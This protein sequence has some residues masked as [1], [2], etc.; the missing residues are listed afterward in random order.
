M[1]RRQFIKTSALSIV[2][3]TTVPFIYHN[4]IAAQSV[5][6]Q[7][8]WIENGT[9]AQ[10]LQSAMQ[11]LGGISSFISRGDVVVIKPNVG[12]DRAPQFAATTNP[13]LVKEIV[14]ACSSA[15]AKTVKLFDRTCNNPLRCYRNSKIEE[16]AK[17]AGAEVSQI[18]KNRFTDIKI[19][20]GEIIKEWPIYRDYLE[21][22]KVINVPIA[23]HHSLCRVT[24]GMKNLMGV[25]GGNR[26]SIHSDFDIKINDINS[27]IMPTLTILD[28]YRVLMNN[29][30]VG[31]DLSDVQLRKTLIASTCTVSV[32]F[33]AL[34]LFGLRINDVS[35]IKIAAERGLNRFDLQKLDVKRIKL[36]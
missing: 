36:S 3:T 27:E 18:R 35:H 10:L 2:A 9:P 21:A 31:G 1:K 32:D 19:K 24:L 7:A 30:P 20:N 12:W 13:E 6:P 11:E 29:G 34:E 15:G 14:K 4:K 22:D 8:V 5:K 23:K 25:M 17:Q 33:L 28:A 16:M 26:G